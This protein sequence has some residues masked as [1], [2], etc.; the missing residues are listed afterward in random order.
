MSQAENQAAQDKYSISTLGRKVFFLYPH[1]VI[2]DEMMNN[3]IM[4]GFE[5]YSL[6]F[7]LHTLS[8]Y[9]LSRTSQA[10]KFDLALYLEL[11]PRESSR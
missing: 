3:L 2:R 8:V 9:P 6:R 10:R 1:S 5:A 11:S 4:S 7:S